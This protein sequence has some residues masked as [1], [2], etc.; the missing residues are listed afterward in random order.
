MPVDLGKLGMMQQKAG[1]DDQE[2]A[3]RSQFDQDHRGIQV[4]RFLD[5]YNQDQSDDKNGEKGDQVENSG[6][7]RHAGRVDAHGQRSRQATNAS[8]Y[9]YKMSP[10]VVVSCGGM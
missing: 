3:D 7:V 6:D 5:P 2:Y 10:G 4:G 9:K 1:T 8:L